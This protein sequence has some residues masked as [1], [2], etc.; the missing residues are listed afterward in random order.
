MTKSVTLL[1][2][3]V[4]GSLTAFAQDFRIDHFKCYFPAESTQVQPAPVQLADQFGPSAAQVGKIFRLCNPTRK[5]HAGVVTGVNH[6]DDHLTLHQT[7]PQPLVTR[8][9]KIRNQFG[10]QEI[11]TL[12]ARILAVPT[13]KAPHGPPQELNH[14]NCYVA[15]GQPVQQ[16]VGLSDQ[17]FASKHNVVRPVLFCNPVQKIHNGAITPITNPNDHLTCYSMTRVPFV[18]DV[19]LR[20]Q[21]GEH[22]I[23]TSLTDMLC[24]PTQKGEWRVVD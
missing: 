11:T 2:V 1:G 12:D 17:F 13:Q 10:D 16:V 18:R 15:Q 14:F 20:N 21:F 23:R 19:D 3:L 9:V 7:T 24:V 6:A 5:F 4:T 22:H 8:Q